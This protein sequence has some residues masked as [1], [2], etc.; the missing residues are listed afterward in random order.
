MGKCLPQNF[1]ITFF[2]RTRKGTGIGNA[3][4]VQGTKSQTEQ[5]LKMLKFVKVRRQSVDSLNG[6]FFTRGFSAVGRSSQRAITVTNIPK[7]TLE[8]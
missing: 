2:C 7:I 3:K 6:R 4:S 8:L 5:G 1:N